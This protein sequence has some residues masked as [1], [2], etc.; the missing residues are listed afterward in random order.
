VIGSFPAGSAPVHQTAE[1]PRAHTLAIPSAR[2]RVGL[3][4]TRRPPT[5]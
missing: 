3:T 4:I 5:A 2:L 1:M